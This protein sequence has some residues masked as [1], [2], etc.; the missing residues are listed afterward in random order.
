MQK[1]TNNQ[2]F[3]PNA[4]AMNA[5]SES[6]KFGTS[7]FSHWL[8][9]FVFVC[10]GLLFSTKSKA[11][12]AVTTNS[13]SGLAATY[14]SLADAITALNAATITG[15]VVIT[16]PT[17]SE[18]APA[19]G[20]NITATGSSD[21]TITIQGNGAAN[22]IITAPTNHTA[23]N[24]FDA[25]FKIKG[26]DFITIQNFTMIENAS[27]TLTA[28]ITNTMTE[29]GVALFYATTT[30]GAQN[31]TIQNNTI[32]L[33]RTYHNTFGIYSNS[34]HDDTNG[35]STATSTAGSNS[36]LKIYGNTISNVNIGIVVFGPTGAADHNTGIDIGGS[37]SANGNTITNFGT[38]ASGFAS[39]AYSNIQPNVHGILVKNSTGF[40]VSYNTITSSNGGVGEA[41]WL[42]GITLAS[43]TNPPTG[44]FTNTINN[45]SIALTHGST[46][47]IHGIKVESSTG[48]ATSTQH[49][50]NN[51]FTALGRS[52]T[53]IGTV[54]AISNAM[55]NLENNF[56]GN[57]FT[58]ITT[59]ESSSF[60]FFSHNYT[61]PAGGSQT[62]NGNSIVTAF[63]KTGAGG[64]VT[65]AT[66]A[67][68]SPNGT[69]HT[70]TNN[71]FSNITVTGTTG[72][73]GVINSDGTSS[74]SPTRTV[75]GNTFANWTGVTGEI[76][77]MSYARIGGTTSTISNN[78]LTNITGQRAITG[79]T[80][81]AT[82]SLATTFNVANN[83]ISN[84]R[85]TGT[86]GVVRG[87]ACT[88]ASPTININANAIN[89]LSSEG[90]SVVTAL[91]IDG[92][93]TTNV[94]QN[95]IYN[96]SGSN[97]SS[98]VNG[99]LITAG[100]TIQVYNN[101]IGNL[102]ASGSTNSDA[103]R[104]ISITSTT[105]NST[106]RVYN[107]TIYL[108]GSSSGTNFGGS[109][110]FH[111]ASG[112]TTTSTLDLQNNIIINGLTPNGT[113][114]AVAFRRSAGAATNLANYAATSDKNLFYAGTP[115]ESNL[116]YSDGTSSA[117]TM[118]DYKA[119]VFT[120]GTIAPRD[121]NSFTEA[122]TSSSFESVTG[123]SANYLQP[124]TTLLTLA[125]S[126]G[127]TISLTSP[128]YNNVVRPGLG[129]TGYDIGAY[130]FSG[131]VPSFTWNGSVGT[132]WN[133]ASNWFHG[134]VPS[135]TDHITISSGKPILDVDFT[136]AGSL[137]ISGTGGLTI[138][139]L[140]SLTISG[141]ADFGGKSV[142]F[143]SDATGAARLGVVSGTLSNATNVSIE[144]YLPS[145]RKWRMLTAPLKGSSNNSVFYN[146]Q[147][148]DLPN[149]ATGVEIWGPAPY[150]TI[151]SSSSN[152][153]LALGANHS[154]RSYGVSGWAPV[155]STN[156]TLLFDNTTNYGYALFATG[157]YNNGS[158][159]Y[160]GSPGSLPAAA[161]TT[162]SA[163]G[164]LITGDHTKSF[165]ASAANQFFLV[166]NPY[167][168]PVDPRSFTE[169]P[170]VN[171]TNLNG[172]LWM[173][174]AKPGAGI[175]NGLGRYVSFDMSINQ[176]NVL[177]DGYADHNVMIQ[178][179][180]AFFVQ[181][182]ASGA[183]TLVFREASKDATSSHAMMGDAIDKKA[184]LRLTLQETVG[185]SS[186]NLDGAVAVFHA[187]GKSGLDPLDGQ[188][189][190]N[191]SENLSL[192]RDD[193]NLS[194]EHRPEVGGT[195]TLMLRIGNMRTQAYVLEASA[196]GFTQKDMT[197][198]LVD[199]LT[200]QR[201]LLDAGGITRYPFTVSSDSLSTGDRF[202]VVFGGR[203][204]GSGV[205]PEGSSV[206]PEL[207]LFPNPATSRLG[208]RYT[209]TMAGSLSLR[210]Y[211]ARGALV[212]DR[213][214]ED[215]TGTG[216]LELNTSALPGGMYRV[217]LTDGAG[218]RQT[219]TFIRR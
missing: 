179:G 122:W 31:C 180:Q 48:T 185:D 181:A 72:L 7:I 126:R 6:I 34:N 197:A 209:V 140:K 57:T 136:V 30:N 176:Y 105:A 156:S 18:T 90:A 39:Y 16:C 155:T 1:I 32:T 133:T 100:T 45:N 196:D 139:P 182:T 145:G 74:S 79:I 23:G 54:V 210:V 201:R 108:T 128:D 175:G 120:A 86:G 81:G 205:T 50:N 191:T 213:T 84:L 29:F 119:G 151:A 160:I 76:T 71:N 194:F 65:I 46:G 164:T 10:A 158:T 15:P 123:S 19:G 174:D 129:G 217:L 152:D 162:L 118:A 216:L 165:T 215:H 142:T 132:G 82:T 178:S 24:L 67:S 102:T 98:T 163:T 33:N 125:E 85:S 37:E 62:F 27:N 148:N 59:N 49:I 177:G 70:F 52:A 35:T 26:G 94:F 146:W 153:G 187:A 22:S 204:N 186:E 134:L 42:E 121:A 73:R 64:M 189:L 21:N 88:N 218:S 44:T 47:T 93:A 112:T 202:M 8:T 200:G 107:N 207:R 131:Q 96:I 168:S 12:F 184:V 166:G 147:N 13:G 60:T 58:N 144:R 188:K 87:L 78:S 25:L 161:A 103:I 170:T 61:M 157:P 137:T 83:T 101:L 9:M 159:A 195:D 14:T 3:V 130:E 38:G 141:T 11:Q 104:G 115:G 95:K 4:N 127:N 106:R 68:S 111:T 214:V 219:Q 110:I 149:G 117:Q 89:T 113:G 172:K 41:F 143:R 171:R 97:A 91:S 193:R 55:P 150:G 192:R 28:I 183:A 56:N 69:F 20:Y 211:D 173:W 5:A 17:G 190:M 99:L 198:T 203:I 80:I 138:N 77:G 124:A 36:G 2:S 43:A 206:S 53:A 135:S 167:A 114:R 51:N 116:I 40:N 109:G 208:V 63:S 169:T 154:M 92:A 66:S 199:R 75:T 212:M